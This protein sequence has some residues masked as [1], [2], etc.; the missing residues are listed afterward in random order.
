RSAAE[1]RLRRVGQSML[2][3]DEVWFVFAGPAFAE[4]GRGFLAS[5]D[6]FAD[7][8]AATSLA[9]ADVV[10][11]FT[12][13]GAAA[14][15]FLDAP[16]VSDDE[17]ADLFPASGP[18]VALTAGEEGQPSQAAAGRRLWLQLI[19]DALSGQAPAALDNGRLT[20]AS[21]HQWTAKELPR[22]VRKV[23]TA[24]RKQSPGLFGPPDAVLAT[25]TA[26]AKKPAARLN[27]KQLKRIV[28]RGETRGKVK[29]LSG[30]QKT[31]KVPEA[32]T[33]SAL[34]WTYRL[35]ADDL[36]AAVEDTYNAVRE[37]LG[38]KRKDL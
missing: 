4:N 1:S 18:A 7:D 38:F 13:T 32:A 22:V 31:F 21:L 20:A 30:F 37:H 8:R 9:V 5:A 28:F 26:T 29:E 27:L 3:A 10:R 15:Y 35:A 23:M 24:P 11:Q 16:G 36:R 25:V 6:T 19:G 2:P 17:L 12:A 33:P 14:R 34:K